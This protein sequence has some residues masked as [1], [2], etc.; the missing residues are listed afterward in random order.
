MDVNLYWTDN[1]TDE[2][3][4]RIYRTT[5]SSPV[6]PGNFEQI[7]SVGADVTEY[8]DTDAPGGR[9]TTYAVV[10]YNAAGESGESTDQV[11]PL[12]TSWRTEA[13]WDAGQQETGVHHEQPNDSDWTASDKVE[14]GYPTFDQDGTA[15]VHY[16]P[17]DEDSGTTAVDATG[18]YN[19]TRTNGVVGPASATKNAVMAPPRR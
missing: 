6:F 3:G 11:V 1:S 9:R 19:G 18:A 15:L 7:D 4:F 17:L 14:K 2:D 13:D 16:W 10:A 8:T 5:I 12:G